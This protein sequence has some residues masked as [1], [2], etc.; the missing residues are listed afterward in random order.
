MSASLRRLLPVFLVSVLLAP[1]LLFSI[2][3][4][5]IQTAAAQNRPNATSSYPGTLILAGGGPLAGTGILETFI[6]RGGGAENGRFVIVPTAGGNY[7]RDG[8]VRVF[9]EDE[10]LAPWRA[11][12]LRHVRM[13]HTHA[14]EIANSDDFVEVVDDAT[15]LW[16]TGG[17][18]WNIVD[19]YAGTRTLE[20]FHGLL[21]RGG[22][23]GGSSAGA[24]IQG[25]Y[26][27]RGDTEGSDIVMTDEPNHMYGFDFLPGTAVDQ[28]IDTR[29]R[30]DDLIPVIEAHPNLLG[31]GLSESTA[32]VVEDGALEVIGRY[33]VTIH[34]NR[35]VYLPW[36]KPYFVLAPGM[37]YDLTTQNNM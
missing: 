36:E 33:M 8:N 4:A 16:F 3:M 18:Q 11:L 26:L 34:D 10:V 12:G 15:A 31:I 7:T 25:T 6:E 17:R 35:R 14:R 21:V 1:V 30:W 9:N 22:V 29:G 27:V 32:I 5:G 37:K 13:L 24:T 28:H 2:P 19:S 23:I 20:A